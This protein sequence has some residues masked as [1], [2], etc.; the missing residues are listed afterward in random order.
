MAGFDAVGQPHPLLFGNGSQDGDE[1]VPEH[2]GAVKVLLSE[3]LEL[4]PGHMEV[5]QVDS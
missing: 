2:A 1:G 4:Y 5:L 3:G